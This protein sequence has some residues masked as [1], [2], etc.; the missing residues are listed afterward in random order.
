MSELVETEA[1]AAAAAEPAAAAT[2]VESDNIVVVG[3]LPWSIVRA[4]P[5]AFAATPPHQTRLLH[6]TTSS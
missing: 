5:A 3:N 6:R 4:L 1:A 2:A